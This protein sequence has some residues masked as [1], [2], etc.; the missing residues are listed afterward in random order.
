MEYSESTIKKSGY[1]VWKR[2]CV[3]CSELDIESFFEVVT[4]EEQQTR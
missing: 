1:N 4:N 2:F 3:L